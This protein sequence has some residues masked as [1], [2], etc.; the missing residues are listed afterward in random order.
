MLILITFSINLFCQED[1][2]IVHDSTYSYHWDTTT[3]DWVLDVRS[4]KTYDINGNLTEENEYE[5][6]TITNYWRATGRG[7]Y[8][9]DAYG[10]ETERIIYDWDKRTTDW[11]YR[12]KWVH[13][14]LALTTSI[15]NKIIDLNHVVYPNPTQGILTIDTDIIGQYTIAISTL[16]GQLLYND[17]L[18]GPT[19]QID[20]S[21]FEK[22]LYFIT[23]RSRDYVRRVKIIKQ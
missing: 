13:Y 19:H 1:S 4:L 9:H 23:V 7:I 6:D 15:S 21:S 2:L 3:N 22:G 11:R 5:W 16:K 8:E 14:W 10:N 12:T 18:E 17:R 20:L